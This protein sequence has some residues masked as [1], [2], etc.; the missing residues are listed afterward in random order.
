M[1]SRKGGKDNTLNKSL[2]QAEIRSTLNEIAS[3]NLS[4]PQL[5]LEDAVCKNWPLLTNRG[6]HTAR[7]TANK[8][9]CQLA[10]LAAALL[11]KKVQE[12]RA[13]A[14]CLHC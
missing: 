12:L 1:T 2:T 3:Y 5:R 8:S 11:V 14:E 4:A 13:P 6:Q 9:C 10:Q 7:V